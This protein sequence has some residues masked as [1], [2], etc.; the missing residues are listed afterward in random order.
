ML[1]LNM[2]ASTAR[3]VM[4]A[5][6]E[7]TGGDNVVP[8][9][10]LSVH[11]AVAAYEEGQKLS[12][13][14][15]AI[16]FYRALVA[17]NRDEP[18]TAKMI[19]DDTIL[20]VIMSVKGNTMKAELQRGVAIGK[21]LDDGRDED[22]DEDDSDVPGLTPTGKIATATDAAKKLNKAFLDVLNAQIQIKEDA[23][24][25]PV[26]AYFALR[27]EAGYTDDE[28]SG[29]PVQGTKRVEEMPD[30]TVIRRNVFDK[31]QK[32][33]TL[34]GKRRKVWG[35]WYRDL[36]DS[37]ALGVTLTRQ[38]DQVNQC[39]ATK[40]RGQLDVDDKYKSMNDT[41]LAAE[42]RRIK[43]RQN[44]GV[45]LIGTAAKLH[46]QIVAFRALEP[47]VVWSWIASAGEQV[48][49][50]TGK[51]IS[52]SQ[53][54]IYIVNPADKTMQDSDCISVS[55]FCL[56]DVDEAIAKGGTFAALLA[57]T[58]RDGETPKSKYPPITGAVDFQAWV[59]EGAAFLTGN[60][61]NEVATDNYTAILAAMSAKEAKALVRSVCD[62]A[63]KLQAIAIKFDPAYRQMIAAD[64]NK[65]GSGEKAAA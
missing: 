31:Y 29:W 19:S 43:D 23:K 6:K 63:A 17:D 21:I 20:E 1:K 46:H 49:D 56:Y 44:T 4:M 13:P 7:G 55:Q 58:G 11:T 35:S 18:V 3:I 45:N 30:G 28:L 50:K 51:G 64:A 2:L 25:T 59:A 60:G 27:N 32:H 48:D 37:S 8:F 41:Q 22:T 33:V 61:N 47:K 62:T 14:Q 52:K 36:F 38:L 40:Q 10:K 15:E 9:P 5:D 53:T 16:D 12:T 65:A 34:D 39:L 57:T 26:V 24:R 42:K 54:P